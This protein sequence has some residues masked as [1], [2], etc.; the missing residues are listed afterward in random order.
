MYIESNNCMIESNNCMNINKCYY[1]NTSRTNLKNA[2]THKST[3]R[4]FRW[5]IACSGHR[6]LAITDPPS[7]NRSIML[8]F[9]Q[10]PVICITHTIKIILH[11]PWKEIYFKPRR[12]M[13]DKKNKSQGRNSHRTLCKILDAR[14][15]LFKTR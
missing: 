8:M 2:T 5:K 15:C 6:R 11:I 1:S 10:Y 3:K 14:Q 13:S 9:E 4:N 12:T 7:P